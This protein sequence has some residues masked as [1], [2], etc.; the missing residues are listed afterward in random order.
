MNGW[1]ARVVSSGRAAMR[2]I[3][4]PCIY[5]ATSSRLVFLVSF[6]PVDHIPPAE[7]PDAEFPW[8]LTTGR[9]RSTYHTGTQTGKA[10]GFQQLVPHEMLEMNPRDAAEM[11][12]VDGD[13]LDVASRRGKV[14]VAARVTERS[15]RGLVFMSFCVPGVYADE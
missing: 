15:P 13:L 12:L 2:T 3:R 7:E 5:T 10:T 1:N 11:G 4:A 6:A 9:R 14:T 8:L